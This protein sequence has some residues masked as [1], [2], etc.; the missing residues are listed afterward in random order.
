VR[1]LVDSCVSK[2]AADQLTEFGHNVVHVGEWPDDPGDEAILNAAHRDSRILI[3]LD[4][5]FGELAIVR[6]LTHSGIVRLVG[7]RA[8]AQG[9]ASQAALERYEHELAEGAIVTVEPGRT[10]VRTAG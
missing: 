10:R 2:F 1:L 9:A 7:L 8:R 6:G 4:K 5:D 3:T